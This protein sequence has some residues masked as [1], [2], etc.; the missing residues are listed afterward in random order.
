LTTN[1]SFFATEPS[2]G[3]DS[4]S[5]ALL[6]LTMARMAAVIAASSGSSGC[7]ATEPVDMRSVV[8]PCIAGSSFDMIFSSQE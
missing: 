4:W 6:E 3:F 7:I 8:D 2:A 1:R 5:R